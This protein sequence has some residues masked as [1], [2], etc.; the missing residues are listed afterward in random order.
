MDAPTSGLTVYRGRARPARESD[1]AAAAGDEARL[2]DPVRDHM[3][4]RL[5]TVGR[6]T[7]LSALLPPFSQGLVPIV[8]DG[9]DFL[10]LVT[11]M[12]AVNFLRRRLS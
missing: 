2:R 12:D 11:R 8:M 1:L 9:D 3:T 5:V 7:E 10:G 4:T 6:S